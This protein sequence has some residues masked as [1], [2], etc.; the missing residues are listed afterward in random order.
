MEFYYDSTDG[1][2]L[3]LSAD[4]GLMRDS[5]PHFVGE[6]EKYIDL[7]MRKLIVDCTRVTR[8][9]SFGLGT[10]VQVHGKLAERGG[11]VKLA[12][13]SG[14]VGKIIGMT[15]LGVLFDIYPTVQEAR[16]AF[17]ADGEGTEDPAPRETRHPAL[18]HEDG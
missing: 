3:I 18:G 17:G 4:G 7:G 16:R 11:D 14:L 5:A 13:V 15:G 8:I 12:A 6:L 1:E 9:T 10:L 2:V